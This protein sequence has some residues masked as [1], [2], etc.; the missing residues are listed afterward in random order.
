LS[1]KSYLELEARKT[2]LFRNGETAN[3]SGC[4][5]PGNTDDG[6]LQAK[7]QKSS[8]GDTW[9]CALFV[10]RQGFQVFPLKKRSKEPLV[11]GWQAKATDNEDVILGWAQSYPDNN[12][13][14]ITGNGFFVL[15]F[16]LDAFD[17]ID[18]EIQKVKGKLGPFEI[19]TLVKTGGGY[20]LYCSAG[21]F[22]IRNN[23]QKRL[24]D[25]VK[26]V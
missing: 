12:Y 23:C 21:G 7:P 22:D 11:S 6:V 8:L 24:T 3:C 5:R 4:T 25:K 26:D 18:S 2:S 10:A 14:V 1:R 9:L 17:N 20:H 15:D 19:G 16:D 13:G